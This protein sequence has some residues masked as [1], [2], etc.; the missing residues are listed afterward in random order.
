MLAQQWPPRWRAHALSIAAG[1]GAA[2]FTAQGVVRAG[3]MLKRL[4][5]RADAAQECSHVVLVVVNGEC[6]GSV[7]VPATL[8]VRGEYGSERARRAV[9]SHSSLAAT[10][11]LA[12]TSKR[13]VSRWPSLED[14]CRGVIPLMEAKNGY[15]L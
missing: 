12:S 5:R 9:S 15:E 14:Q 3:D 4:L 11:A 7:A 13:Q 2:N 8:H 10:S 6:E 1:V